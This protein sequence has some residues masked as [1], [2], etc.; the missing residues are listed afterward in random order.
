MDTWK[1]RHKE[2]SGDE[3]RCIVSMDGKIKHFAHSLLGQLPDRCPLTGF[4][5][6]VLEPQPLG[7]C[8][9]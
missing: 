7:D 3:G 5:F 9:Y 1:R 6:G 8:L 4:V 2:S